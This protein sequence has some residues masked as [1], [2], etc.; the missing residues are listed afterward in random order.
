[1]KALLTR[2][3]LQGPRAKL[4]AAGGC[5][6]LLLLVGPLAT[7]SV[8]GLARGLVAA[9][10][11]GGAGWW[12]SRR[13]VPRASFAL[14]EPMQVLSRK[15]LSA[16]CSIALVQVDGQR[17]L[18]TYGEGFAQLQAL[19]RRKK[20]RRCASPQQRSDLASKVLP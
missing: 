9:L 12:L 4:L 17:F 13:G 20:L 6:L 10:A 5:M 15:G 3:V 2:S 19:P 8:V 16:R 11:L 14:A 7:P 1:M 18:V